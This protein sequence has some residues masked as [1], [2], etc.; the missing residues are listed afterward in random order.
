M[1][2]VLVTL[3]GLTATKPADISIGYSI[4]LEISEVLIKLAFIVHVVNTYNVRVESSI[5]CS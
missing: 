5:E 4:N 3:A 1:L 2:L